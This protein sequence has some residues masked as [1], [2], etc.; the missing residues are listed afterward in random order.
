MTILT[1]GAIANFLSQRF[2]WLKGQKPQ[3]NDKIPIFDNFPVILEI[4]LYRQSIPHA[5]IGLVYLFYVDQIFNQTA[6]K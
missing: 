2:Q 6:V 4:S 3:K 5:K 1:I